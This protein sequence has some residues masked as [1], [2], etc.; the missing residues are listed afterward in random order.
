MAQ[1]TVC[2]TI[3]ISTCFQVRINRLKKRKCSARRVWLDIDY[4]CVRALLSKCG[5]PTARGCERPL[6]LARRAWLPGWPSSSSDCACCCHSGC[7]R[8][9]WRSCGGCRSLGPGGLQESKTRLMTIV[10][11]INYNLNGTWQASVLGSHAWELV[12]SGAAF[13]FSVAGDSAGHGV[14]VPAGS[15]AL[16]TFIG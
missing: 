16:W 15:R 7:G 14:R 11:G 10:S 12:D 6:G 1:S 9:E 5:V 4:S 13:L 8:C 3:S 2:L